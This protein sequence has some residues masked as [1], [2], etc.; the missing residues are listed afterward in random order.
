MYKKRQAGKKTRQGQGKG[1]KWSNRVGSKR[2]RGKANRGQG[3]G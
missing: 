2:N 1:S 3:K